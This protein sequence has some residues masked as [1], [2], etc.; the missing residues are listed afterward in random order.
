MVNDQGSRGARLGWA[1]A[2]S[3]GW[4]LVMVGAT[5][6]TGRGRPMAGLAVLAP[7]QG[8]GGAGYHWGKGTWMHVVIAWS[9][10]KGLHMFNLYGYDST[11]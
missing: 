2:E 6:P 3:L 9:S 1:K 5:Q 7:D 8:Q 11:Q 10:N 4:Q